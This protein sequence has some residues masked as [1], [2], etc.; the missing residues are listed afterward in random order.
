MDLR[1]RRQIRVRSVTVLNN[2]PCAYCS[3]VKDTVTEV[4]AHKLYSSC[5]GL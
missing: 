1:K 3:K 5:N 4:M 2:K